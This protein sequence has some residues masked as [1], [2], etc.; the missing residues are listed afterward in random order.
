ML[1][2]LSEEAFKAVTELRDIITKTPL[3]N[4][5]RMEAYEYEQAFMKA[6]SLGG[7]KEYQSKIFTIRR[8]I[9]DNAVLPEVGYRELKRQLNQI[10]KI[11]STWST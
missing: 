11:L 6:L 10:S 9:L 7:N 4:R 5:S 8:I 1:E 3:A 2:I